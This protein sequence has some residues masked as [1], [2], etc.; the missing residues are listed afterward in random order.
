MS[1]RA[2]KE[3][4][5]EWPWIIRGID[6]VGDHEDDCIGIS[7]EKP[8][9]REENRFT[10]FPLF[11]VAVENVFRTLHAKRSPK[12]STDFRRLYRFPIRQ[13]KVLDQRQVHFWGSSE[14]APFTHSINWIGFFHRELMRYRKFIFCG[15][16]LACCLFHDRP[17][18]GRHRRNREE[19]LYIRS[20]LFC[21][22]FLHNFELH[23]SPYVFGSHRAFCFRVF[24][25]TVLSEMFHENWDF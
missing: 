10:R 21:F 16:W 1:L 9:T 8:R 19:N 4:W 15:F 2:G 23:N 6:V 17:H 24:F 25:A 22:C 13:E 11:A 5:R 18:T 20:C 3:K 7:R 14:A 12:D